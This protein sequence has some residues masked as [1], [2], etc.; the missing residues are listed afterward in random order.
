MAERGNPNWVPGK[1]VNPGGKPRT[2]KKFQ[3][4]LALEIQARTGGQAARYFVKTLVDFIQF[5]ESHKV[6]FAALQLAMAYFM[7]KPHQMIEINATVDIAERLRRARE[8][9]GLPPIVEEM[10]LVVPDT[11]DETNNPV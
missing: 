1:A 3:E 4:L 2:Q 9:V 5:G 8:R 6:K 11:D 7:G 10:P